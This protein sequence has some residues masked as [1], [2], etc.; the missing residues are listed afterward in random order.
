[1]YM[2]NDKTSGHER[3]CACV[4]FFIRV[5]I[6]TDFHAHQSSHVVERYCRLPKWKA[7][8]EFPTS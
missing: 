1:M 5:D 8:N 3:F 4:C 2:W 7:Y 6:L